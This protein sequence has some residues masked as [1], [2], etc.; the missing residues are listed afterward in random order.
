M[1]YQLHWHSTALDMVQWHGDEAALEAIPFY[2][3]TCAGASLYE[4]A[5]AQANAVVPRM[6][7]TSSYLNWMAV[8]FD[9]LEQ[10]PDDRWEF[11]QGGVGQWDIFGISYERRFWPRYH[12]VTM[13]AVEA[14]NSNEPGYFFSIAPAQAPG[15]GTTKMEKREAIVA[16]QAT[17]NE[18][19]GVLYSRMNQPVETYRIN[20][21]T[22]DHHYDP[23]YMTWVRVTLPPEYASRRGDPLYGDTTEEGRRG[24][25]I[26]INNTYQSRPE[27]LLV[28]S[29]MTWQAES[30]YYVEGVTDTNRGYQ[31]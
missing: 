24:L 4:Q 27:G 25:P 23:G 5:Q 22:N 20:L 11:E 16:D 17:L 8:L 12:W 19:T 6:V 3:R 28:Q 29:T 14:T 31:A 26:E 13:A 30:P 7:F 15:M 18:A 10:H 21:G 1:H 2:A 9:P